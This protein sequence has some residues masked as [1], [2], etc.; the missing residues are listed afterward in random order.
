MG[1][2][3]DPREQGAALVGAQEGQK[4]VE[5]GVVAGVALPEVALPGERVG[6]GSDGR[7]GQV[8]VLGFGAW[9]LM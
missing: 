5:E 1:K 6:V 9:S 2:G 3:A 8:K 7:Q 4:M